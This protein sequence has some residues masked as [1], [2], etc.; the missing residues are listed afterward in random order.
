[1]K[2]RY[3]KR[4]ICSHTPQ[5]WSLSQPDRDKETIH[6]NVHYTTP[7]L[8]FL[9]SHRIIRVRSYCSFKDSSSKYLPTW[10]ITSL[11]LEFIY[12]NFPFSFQSREKVKSWIT[13]EFIQEFRVSSINSPERDIHW[14]GS[15]RIFFIWTGIANNI[16]TIWCYHTITGCSRRHMSPWDWIMPQKMKFSTC[17]SVCAINRVGITGT[18]CW[19]VTC[20]TINRLETTFWL[21][22]ILSGCCICR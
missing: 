8:P 5:I 21:V 4:F 11:C 17:F 9:P 2:N 20:V 3:D 1:M 13:V 10:E 22:T 12:V 18:W 16:S 7:H 6:I 15:S 19:R 14:F